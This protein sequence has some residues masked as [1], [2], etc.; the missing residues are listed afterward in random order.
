MPVPCRFG[1]SVVV[2]FIFKRINH[3]S[4]GKAPLPFYSKPI[5]C[6]SETLSVSCIMRETKRK[7]L[8]WAEIVYV[9]PGSRLSTVKKPNEL[10]TTLR[11][12]PSSAV[13]I[14]FLFLI[15]TCVSVTARPDIVNRVA[16]G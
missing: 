12:V 7:R 15:P 14:T 10:V 11:E 9:K 13:M 4:H 6:R 16:V 8:D 2:F 5:N 1:K 3:G